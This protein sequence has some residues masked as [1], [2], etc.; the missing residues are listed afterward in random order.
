MIWAKNGKKVCQKMEERERKEKRSFSFLSHSCFLPFLS[1]HI[2]SWLLPLGSH[3]KAQGIVFLI[4]LQNRFV[5]LLGTPCWLHS[6]RVRRCYRPLAVAAQV[7]PLSTLL[8]GSEDLWYLQVS[9][10]RLSQQTVPSDRTDGVETQNTMH[11]LA[12]VHS[13]QQASR[14]RRAKNYN[15]PRQIQY[16]TPVSD[17]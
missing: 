13:T 1:K 12:R 2:S 4:V 8:D 6:P 15:E 14:I 5:D 11:N 3:F 16:L 9:S 17:N 10:S 7:D